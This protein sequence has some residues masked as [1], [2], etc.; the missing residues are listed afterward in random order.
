MK[1][2][3]KLALGASAILLASTV[4]RQ[5]AAAPA[6]GW[7]TWRGPRQNG[8]SLE[9]N[10]PDQIDV[11]NPVWMADFPGQSTPVI[12]DGKVYVMGYVG[13]GAELV[14]GVACFDAETGKKLWDQLYPDFLSDTIYLRYASSSPTIDPETGN[15]CMQGSQG[16]FTC[17]SPDG[18]KLWERSLMELYGRLT[19][20]NARTAP[21]AFDDDL[22][23]ARGITAN[24]GA[25]GPGGDRF[26][27]FDKKSGELV[28]SSSPGAQ[29]KDNSFS[30]P[31]FANWKGM[32]VFYSA[33]GDGSVVCVNARTG[34][35]LWRVPLFK[36]GINA[37]VLLY[38][39]DTLISIFGTPYEP[40]KMVAIKIPD[41]I[42]NPMSAGPVVVLPETVTLWQ[43]E[44]RT[45]SSSPILVGDKVYLVNET[46]DLVSVDAKT[47]KK[48]WR[49][50]LGIEQRNACPIFADGRLYVPLLNEPGMK[51]D[52]ADEAAGG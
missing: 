14:E 13:Q 33:T 39:G 9:K 11:K 16:I 30:H 2:S 5:A 19:F 45:S 44:L 46:G 15:V 18:K 34:D 40:G 10:L 25:Q 8:T 29:P 35:P 43:N 37:S 28:W 7:L 32:R 3:F 23:I 51:S 21:P 4:C 48:D 26:Y 27:A 1:F 47:G 31:V 38:N 41:A 6:T 52:S 12:A 36:A 24:W 50:K 22:V 42:P 49:I 20:P 17:S